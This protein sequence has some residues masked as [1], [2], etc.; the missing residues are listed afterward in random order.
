MPEPYGNR[1]TQGTNLLRDLVFPWKGSPSHQHRDNRLLFPECSCE[2]DADVVLF[3]VKSPHIFAWVSHRQP[4]ATNDRK[5]YIAAIEL[6]FNH[7][8]KIGAGA[9]GHVQKHVG[10][11]A[12]PKSVEEPSGR[13]SRII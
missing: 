7:L 13:S 12:L 11:A 2:L 10:A 3:F 8:A 1:V 9:R 5:Y 6:L 4:R